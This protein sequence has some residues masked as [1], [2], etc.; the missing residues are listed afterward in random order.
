M[1]LSRHPYLAARATRVAGTTDDATLKQIFVVV[2]NAVGVDFSEYKS[3]TLER[4]LGPP[5]GAAPHRQSRGA[6]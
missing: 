2:R 1:R 6:T 3:A 5:D 4:R